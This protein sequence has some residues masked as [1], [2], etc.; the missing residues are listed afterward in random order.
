MSVRYETY[1]RKIAGEDVDISKMPPPSDR[2]EALLRT[3]AENSVDPKGTLGFVMPEMYGAIGDGL[4]NDTAAFQAALSSGYNVRCAPAKTYIVNIAS[5]SLS[6]LIVSSNTIIDLNRSTIKMGANDFTHYTVLSI[7]GVSNVTVKNGTVSGNRAENTA[8]GEHGHVI[9]VFE[10]DHVMLENLTVSEGFGD[11]IYVG[12]ST[13]STE[14]LALNNVLCYHNRR[15]NCSLVNCKH[16]TI[17]NSRFINATGTNPQ[18]GLDIETNSASDYADDIIITGCEFAENVNGGLNAYVHSADNTISITDCII[19]GV[20]SCSWLTSGCTFNMSG[21]T[22][23]PQ[24]NSTAFAFQCHASSAITVN[25]CSVNCINNPLYVLKLTENVPYDF[26]NISLNDL[27]VYGGTIE[28]FTLVYHGDLVKNCHITA[29]L[30]GVKATTKTYTLTDVFDKSNY[31]R[32]Y[33]LQTVVDGDVNFDSLGDEIS[34]LSEVTRVNLNCGRLNDHQKVYLFCESGGRAHGILAPSNSYLFE[35]S[36]GNTAQKFD[37][38]VGQRATLEM[39][40]FRGR[41][42]YKLT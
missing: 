30:D 7:A 35:D 36:A 24:A 17:A 32:T 38:L 3:I 14:Y 37:I 16:V 5:N 42:Y 41:I 25:G 31:V 34:I 18:L 9:A 26:K 8:S 13:S 39:D 20:A 23:I 10:S 33:G 4:T 12:G 2:Y 29:R 27:H 15:N 28:R 19:N 1:L 6:A 22:I 40:E 11:G 21:C